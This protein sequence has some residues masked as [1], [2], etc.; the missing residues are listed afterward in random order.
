MR[1]VVWR[2]HDRFGIKHILQEIGAHRLRMECESKHYPFPKRLG[3]FFLEAN[4]DCTFLVYRYN[5]GAKP[6]MKLDA[7]ALPEKGWERVKV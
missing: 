5:D 2:N 3:F 6:V 7:Y 1:T 4:D